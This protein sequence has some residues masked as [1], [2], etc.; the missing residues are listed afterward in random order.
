MWTCIVSQ[1]EIEKMFKMWDCM[2]KRD[3]G[4]EKDR[5]QDGKTGEQEVGRE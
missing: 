3:L 2:G 4:G 5:E 1:W